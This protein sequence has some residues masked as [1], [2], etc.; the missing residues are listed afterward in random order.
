VALTFNPV[1]GMPIRRRAR[2]SP[3]STPAA[4]PVAAPT[5]PQIRYSAPAAS[6]FGAPS[7]TPPPD[8]GAAAAVTSPRVDYGQGTFSGGTPAGDTS[9]RVEFGRG[10]F[11]ADGGAGAAAAKTPSEELMAQIEADPLYQQFKADM[12]AEDASSIAQ[13]QAA[14]RRAV[15]LSDLF[16]P[17]QLTGGLS[18]LAGDVDPMTI[19]LA[20]ENTKAG[21]ST[22]A[23]LDLAHKDADTGI[24]NSLAARGMLNSGETGY[25][26]G[27]EDTTYRRNTFDAVQ[28]LLDYL[29]QAEGGYL[30]SAKGRQR[31]LANAAAAAAGR[32]DPNLYKSGSQVTDLG[33]T[34][35]GDPTGVYSG[36]PSNDAYWQSYWR[37]KHAAQGNDPWT[38]GL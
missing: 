35:Y 23:R 24:T 8:P 2:R 38:A 11:G 21:I 5:I 37:A 36:D 16:N 27:R 13:R 7:Q 3:L 20:A 12:A 26:L 17:S 10:T 14:V 18:A 25:H 34:G 29:S 30:E 31:D 15:I 28:Q 9:P 22:R 32:L 19:N 4:P 1:T 33:D 6:S